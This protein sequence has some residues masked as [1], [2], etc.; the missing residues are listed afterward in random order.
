MK[1]FPKPIF[2]SHY[3]DMDTKPNYY[4]CEEVDSW[5]Q[6][7]AELLGDY[8]RDGYIDTWI[9]DDII[10]GMIGHE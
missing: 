4:S 7:L 2:P 3:S 1:P 10:T 6:E 9:T 5:L 8:N